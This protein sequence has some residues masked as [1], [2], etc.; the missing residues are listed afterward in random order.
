MYNQCSIKREIDFW[1][2]GGNVLSRD[3]FFP[4]HSRKLKTSVLL[5]KKNLQFPLL[6]KANISAYMLNQM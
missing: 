6:S 3:E 4:A 1:A 5:T 2:V